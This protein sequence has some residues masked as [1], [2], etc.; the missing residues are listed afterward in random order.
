MKSTPTLQSLRG[1]TEL[2]YVNAE[3]VMRYRAIM[4]FFYQEYQRLRYWLKPEEVYEG[5]VSWGIF[6]QYTFEQCQ[7]DLEQLVE[8]K[9]LA[10]RHDGGRSATVEEY[11]RKKYQYLLTPYSIEIERLLETLE[12]VRGY[13]G[14]LEP[15]LFD[16]IADKL[17][18]IR[19]KADIFEPGEALE[20]WNELYESFKRLH[21]TS[22]DY[23][24]SLQT[25]RAEELMATDAFLVYKETLTDYLQNFVQALQRRAYKI[26]GN[27]RQISSH[28]RDLFLEQIA[29]DEL[30]KPRLEDTP[31]QEDLLNELL[32]GW[33][34]LQRWFMGEG[35][36]PSE[37][38]LLER[39]TK[40]AIAR[41]VRCVLRIQER[42]R[43]GLSRR[44]E[45]DY[46]GQWFYNTETLDE[47]HCLA[48]YVFGLFPTRHL[49]GE[50]LRESDRADLSMWQE[51]PTIR[52]LR[53]RSRKRT[54][55]HDT[56]PVREHA[57]RRERAKERILETQREELRLLM[58]MV[59][60]GEVKMSELGVV[61]SQT[62]LRLL[63]WIGRCI[64]SSAS[65][66]RTP[67]G[68]E[69]SL[70]RPNP[71]ETTVLY[72]EDGELELP[73]YRLFFAMEDGGFI[74]V[75]ASGQD[76]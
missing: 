28:V 69:V 3:N 14:S 41:I 27:L 23:I 32:Q 11:L 25:S 51:K 61:S 72:C 71:G 16:T 35:N 15:T 59:G 58:Q 18:L 56:E 47:A 24:A 67:E 21:Q 75:A 54:D 8:W 4:R 19:S 53:S 9:N 6:E 39:A 64:S 49:Q 74:E 31:A 70:S 34:N 63:S 30:R 22:V 20:L 66:F 73:D 44:K 43:S 76:E 17:F 57:E 29:A 48:A 65:K 60:L 33:H 10:S 62:R 12:T 50:D 55:R 38:M 42:K 26:E 68:I 1:V 52:A 46:L 36:A 2:K 40:D 13:G 7:M 5:L 37:L 45:L